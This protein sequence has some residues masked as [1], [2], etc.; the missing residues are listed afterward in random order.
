MSVILV[1]STYSILAVLRTFR[2]V[3]PPGQDPA[4]YQM[5]DV[6]AHY[7]SLERHFASPQKYEAMTADKLRGILLRKTEAEE[8][9]EEEEV[10]ALMPQGEE[11]K[12]KKSFKKKKDGKNTLRKSL[13]SGAAVYGK[14]LVEEVIRASGVD[15]NTLITQI[16]ND[17]ILPKRTFR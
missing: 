9:V 7:S 15:G 8:V 5:Y 4:K 1:S 13:L 10:N 11:K 2:P 17:G 16:P 14:E 12:S 6:G 3:V